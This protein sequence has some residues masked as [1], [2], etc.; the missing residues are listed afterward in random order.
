[1]QM[2]KERRRGGGGNKGRGVGKKRRW[3]AG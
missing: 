3:L 2:E 1:L